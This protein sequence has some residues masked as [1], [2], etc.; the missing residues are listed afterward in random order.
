MAT[1]KKELL[2]QETTGVE[3]PEGIGET[4]A[5][6]LSAEI[7]ATFETGGAEGETADE[8]ALDLN[9]LLSGMDQPSDG[10]AEDDTAVDSATGETCGDTLLSQSIAADIAESETTSEE[11]VPAAPPDSEGDGSPA[12]KAETAKPRRAARKKQGC[13]YICRAGD[14]R[15]R[16]K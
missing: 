15:P 4:D 5:G 13:R 12:A 16:R 8:T 11:T 14:C 9:E 7:S 3:L 1:K 6:D 2:S 10:A